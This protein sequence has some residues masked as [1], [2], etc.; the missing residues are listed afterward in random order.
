MSP[1]ILVLYGTT[2][3]QTRKISLE[4][5]QTLRTTGADVD[6]AN[7]AG[8]GRVPAPDEYDTVIVAGSV[9]AGG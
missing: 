4:L 5:G 1:R 7:A 9:H 8:A 2:D 3:R 6:A